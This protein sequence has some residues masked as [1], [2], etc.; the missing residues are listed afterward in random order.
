MASGCQQFLKA[1]W[2]VTKAAMGRSF[3][4]SENPMLRKQL[5]IPPE[6]AKEFLKDMR[7][8]HRAK[9]Q[10]IGD[11][12]AANAAWKLKQHLPTERS[13]GCRT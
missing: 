1:S 6:A 9:G 8:C 4:W 11:E 2:T 12:I 3:A 10:R 5:L 13:C 7:A